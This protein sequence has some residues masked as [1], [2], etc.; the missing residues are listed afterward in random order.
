M[1]INIG[2]GQEF[3][4]RKKKVVLEVDGRDAYMIW[5]W[6]HWTV[7]WKM[8]KMVNFKGCSRIEQL[9]MSHGCHVLFALQL[10]LKCCINST[11]SVCQAED[12]GEDARTC[13]CFRYYGVNVLSRS[14]TNYDEW[15]LM[16]HW[17]W[18]FS[19]LDM[20][21]I[22]FSWYLDYLW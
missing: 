19:G 20:T 1:M 5:V 8:V 22:V 18:S 3:H 9:G 15:H 6:C 12:L 17:K 21:N 16:A 10:F 4:F 7:C 13:R 14:V 11:N 2:V